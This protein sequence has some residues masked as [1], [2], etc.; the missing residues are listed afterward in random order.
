MRRIHDAT[1]EEQL[2]APSE[3]DVQTLKA[4]TQTVLHHVAHGSSIWH[5]LGVLPLRFG[6]LLDRTVMR[7]QCAMDTCEFRRSPWSQETITAQVSE[8]LVY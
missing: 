3:H 1:L 7:T 2:V 8:A 6:N 5:L 4:T